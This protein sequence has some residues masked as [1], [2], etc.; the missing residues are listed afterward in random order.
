MR[1]GVL[2]VHHLTRRSAAAAE[3]FEYEHSSV[4]VMDEVRFVAA[5]LEKLGIVYRIESIRQ[6]AEL[7]EILSRSPERIVFNLVEDLGRNVS[8]YCYV[9]AVCHAFGK[10]CTGGDTRCLLLAQDKWR[11]K[12]VLK[13]AGLSCPDGFAVPLGDPAPIWLTLYSEFI[14]YGE[15]NRCGV[16]ALAPGKYI[17]KPVLSDASEGIDAKSVVDLPSMSLLDAVR[18]VHEQLKQPALVEQFIPHRELNVSLLQRGDEV[19][20]LPVAEID[21]SAFG[22]DYPRIVDYSA[23][24]LSGSFA[25]NNTP[26]VIPA[27]LNENLAQSIRTAALKAWHVLDCRDFARVDFRVDEK[28]N[29]FILE[30]NPNPDISPDAGFAAALA[31]AKIGFEE[32]VRILLDNASA[33]LSRSCSKASRCA[34]VNEKKESAE[35]KY[36]VHL[37]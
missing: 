14:R 29:I 17:V 8:D 12:A 7:P 26:R 32:F 19:M 21:F 3:K 24:W 15:P 6:I 30:V 31:A 27:P 18:R 9:P 2:I 36:T 16:P 33:F 10:V 20:V 1:K 34:A 22:N 37:S 13:A 28:D 5:A 23:K 11:T 25:Y 4:S 35:D